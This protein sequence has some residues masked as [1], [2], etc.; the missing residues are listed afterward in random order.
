MATN[1]DSRMPVL[2]GGFLL[3]LVALAL[4]CYMMGESLANVPVTAD[5]SITVLQAKRI[6]EGQ[7]PLLV[8]AQPYQ[9]PLE[10]Y[11]AA[12]LVKVVPR[13]TLGARYVSFVEGFAGLLLLLLIVR[14]LGPWSRTWPMMVLILFPSAYLLMIQFGYSLPHNSPVYLAGWGALLLIM[15]APPA[16]SWSRCFRVLAAGVLCGLAFTNNMLAL[17]LVAP[18]L[19]V[20]ALGGSWRQIVPNGVLLALGVAIGLIPYLAAIQLYPGAHDMVAGTRPF[21]EAL[22]YLWH[23]TMTITLTRA[24]GITP[25]F[26]PDITS[27]LEVGSWLAPAMPFL[28]AGF[29]VAATLIRGVACVRRLISQKALGLDVFDG[30]VGVAWLNLIVFVMSERSTSDAYRYLA[31]AAWSFP[32]LVGGVYRAAGR[33]LRVGIGAFCIFLAAVNVWTTVRLAQAWSRPEFVEYDVDAPDLKS[34]LNYLRQAGI[35][36][37][38]ASHWQ[39]YRINFYSDEKILC[40]QPLNERFPG[41]PLPYKEQVDLATNV[42]YVLSDRSSGNV[43]PA[44][45]EGHL[46][47]M[48]IA[49]KKTV[50][51]KFSIYSDF[52]QD[53]RQAH[54]VRVPPEALTVTTSHNP[55]QAWQLLDSR[56]TRWTTERLQEKGMWIQFHL[57]KPRRLSRMVFVYDD[58]FRDSAPRI[59][60]EVKTQGAWRMIAQNV[61]NDLD[62]FEFENGHPIYWRYLQTLASDPILTDELRLEIVEPN[63]G[64]SWTFM[65]IELYEQKP[66]P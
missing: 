46:N 28:F 66:E 17:A 14:R 47:A 60:V 38:V 43:N 56:I 58:Y 45:F 19:I 52:R 36:H 2:V 37:C 5:E 20:A 25:A 24:L 12:P 11:L 41:W 9:F 54:E 31:P 39:A 61:E 10:A 27:H 3:L 26:F 57:Q 55:T 21:S 7:L 44:A 34:A 15:E 65:A 51:G 40:S 42:A 30:F 22:P 1:N 29:L 63:P 23:P 4:R 59:N 49:A 35:T 6:T 62:P 8:L 16:Y 13:H 18:I 53:P 32:F 64:R 33:W 48:R 50:R